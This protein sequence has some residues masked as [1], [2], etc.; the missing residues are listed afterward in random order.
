[1]ARIRF[2][3]VGKKYPNGFVALENLNLDVE[4]P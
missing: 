2:D 4:A 3:S 1:M